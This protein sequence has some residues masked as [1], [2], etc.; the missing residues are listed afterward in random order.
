MVNAYAARC[1]SDAGFRERSLSALL[2]SFDACRGLTDKLG[3]NSMFKV[4]LSV[5]VVKFVRQR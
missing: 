5:L 3:A 4:R 2:R 1:V